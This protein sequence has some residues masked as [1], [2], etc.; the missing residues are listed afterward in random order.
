MLVPL[1][2][3]TGEEISINPDQ[4]RTL[5]HR[6]TA[7]AQDAQPQYITTITFMDGKSE[8]VRG[9]QR[10]VKQLLKAAGWGR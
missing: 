1:E 2:L 4:I 3:E 5:R 9:T 10:D 7:P 8:K 6:N